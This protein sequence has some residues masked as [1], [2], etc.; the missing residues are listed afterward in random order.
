M[1]TRF[2]FPSSGSA[3]VSTAFSSVWT[4]ALVNTQPS[5]PLVTSKSNTALAT[6]TH[7]EAVA[8]NPAQNPVAQFISGTLDVD[9]TITGT[10]SGILFG[11]ESSASANASLQ[12]VVRVVSGDGAI[13]RG[14]L[15]SG[16]A[17]AN[18]TTV[19]DAWGSEFGTANSTR[20]MPITNVT[21]VNAL[22]GDRIVVEVGSRNSNS[23]TTSYSTTLQFGD[24]T[25]T[26]DYARTAGL[27]TAGDGWIELSQTVTLGT[28]ASVTVHAAK[29]NVTVTAIAPTVSDGRSAVEP[30]I[31]STGIIGGSWANTTDPTA[32]TAITAQAGDRILIL[33]SRADSANWV[34]VSTGSGLSWATLGFDRTTNHCDVEVLAAEV[35]TDGTYNVGLQCSGSGTPFAGRYWV[36]RGSDGFGSPVFDITNPVSISLATSQDKS[37]IFYM[38]ADWTAL[39]ATTTWSAIGSATRIDYDNDAYV[40]GQYTVDSVAFTGVTPAGTKTVAN[41]TASTVPTLV[42]IE[43][44]GTLAA[45]NGVSIAAVP[46]TVSVAALNP[47]V[48]AVRHIAVAAVAAAISIGMV[49]PTVSTGSGSTVNI[50]AVAAS[51]SVMASAPAVD[52]ETVIA[53]GGPAAVTIAALAP[54]IS[55]PTDS[56]TGTVL[57]RVVF[58]NPGNG[59]NTSTVDPASTSNVAAGTPFTPTAGRFLVVLAE[60]AVTSTTPTGWTLPVGGSAIQNTGLYAWYRNAAGGDTFTT[61]HNGT[62]YPMVF[63]VLEFAAGSSFLDAAAQVGIASN[64]NTGPS[65]SGLTGLNYLVGIVGQANP[66]SVDTNTFTWSAGTKVSDVCHPGVGGIDGFNYSTTVAEQSALSTWGPGA[67]AT[68]STATLERL[69]IAIHAVGTGNLSV[70]AVAA[71]VNVA[72]VAPAVQAVKNVS[73]TAVAATVSIAARAPVIETVGSV[74]VTAVTATV[75]VAARAPSVIVVRHVSTTA[76]VATAGIAAVAPSVTAIKTVDIAAVKA[77]ATVAARAPQVSATWVVNIDAVAATASVSAIAPLVTAVKQVEV[78]A[79]IAAVDIAAVAPSVLAVKQVQVLATPA[80]VSFAILAPQVTTGGFSTLMGS[81]D[82]SFAIPVESLGVWNGTATIPVDVLGVWDGSTIR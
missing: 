53:G 13:E 1:A 15:Y 8:T 33:A 48:S 29:T 7:A 22:A 26:S 77:T 11:S 20:T 42:A 50:T 3:P 75:A 58:N 62:N 57:N 49:A 25:A 52:A 10:F 40:S 30:T 63:E 6:L 38:M 46:A 23:S 41:D 67:I 72:A 17:T 21:S 37:T 32:T 56:G 16:H 78:V 4:P 79:T 70:T 28:P 2:Y 44:K 19:A 68:V 65:I 76:V 39:N 9:Q 59:T 12:V 55:T 51:A 80:G 43:V 24:P 74:T 73:I 81:W 31:V 45:A 27:T 66:I 5:R 60:G 47:V 35:T 64:A 18:S 69:V 61:T 34:V 54:T 71:T 36:L 82:R 14:V